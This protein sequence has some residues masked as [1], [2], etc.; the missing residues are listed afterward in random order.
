MERIKGRNNSGLPV[1]FVGLLRKDPLNCH[2]I[3]Q[4]VERYLID[5]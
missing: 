2:G 5:F 3:Q 4:T 1:G